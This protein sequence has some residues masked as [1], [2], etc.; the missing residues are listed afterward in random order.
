MW[1]LQAEKV[2]TEVAE[3]KKRDQPAERSKKVVGQVVHLELE[4]VKAGKVPKI[5][6]AALLLHVSNVPLVLHVSCV[7]LEF[8]E[9]MS[10]IMIYGGFV[11][12]PEPVIDGIPRAITN[13][14]DAWL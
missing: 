14:E 9:G 8:S 1:S 2:Q 11:N 13:L 6:F 10:V 12:H 7:P 4:A 3:T 5:A